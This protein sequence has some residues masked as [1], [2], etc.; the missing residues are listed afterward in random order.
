MNSVIYARRIAKIALILSIFLWLWQVFSIAVEKSDQ[1]AAADMA[2]YQKR[3]KSLEAEINEKTD[4]SSV[5]LDCVESFFNGFTFGV[6]DKDGF[7][8]PVKRDREWQNSVRT[9]ADEYHHGIDKAN[10]N[11]EAYRKRFLFVISSV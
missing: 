2:Y 9:R 8:G 3:M 10:A 11:L 4:V 7:G 1:S 6:F 5:A